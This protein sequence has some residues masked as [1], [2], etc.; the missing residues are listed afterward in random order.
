MPSREATAGIIA[1]GAIVVIAVSALLY[2]NYFKTSTGPSK[3]T[4]KSV[5]GNKPPNKSNQVLVEDDEE[6][7]DTDEDDEEEDEAAPISPIPA[8]SSQA[9]ES[10][11][12]KEPNLNDEEIASLKSQY[13]DAN[14]LASKLI[15]GN[16][17]ARAAEK[18]TEIIALARQVPGASKD[19]VKLY[20]N[21]SA[22]FE[23]TQEFDKSLSDIQVVLTLDPVHVKARVRQARVF[24]AQVR[25]HTLCCLS[26]FA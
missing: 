17:Y 22:M 16:A 14:R 3:N 18:L 13:D 8:E 15:S 19:L 25:F 4:F 6:E 12:R 2:A 10:K 21:R 11:A 20:N 24:E 5:E 9:D 26:F 1:L 7:S 23:K